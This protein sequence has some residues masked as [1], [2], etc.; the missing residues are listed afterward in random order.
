MSSKKD[1]V[2]IKIIGE[3]TSKMEKLNLDS[4][5][6]DIRRRLEKNNTINDTY[7]F[8]TRHKNEFEEIE[9]DYED[10][11]LLNEIIEKLDN[12]EN[13][14]LYLMKN[15]RLYWKF[16]IKECDIEYGRTVSFDGIKIS[17]KRLFIVQDCGFNLFSAEKY[18][19]GRF[20]C[21]S[22][23]D[24]LKERNLFFSTN[25]NIQGFMELGTSLEDD[26]FQNE[27]ID[28]SII[29]QYIELGKASLKFYKEN[30]KLTQGFKNEVISAIEST[31]PKEFKKIIE[32]YG[33]FIP[34]EV[35]L[36]KRVYFENFK[37][38]SKILADNSK[39]G[40]VG[41]NSKFHNI[42]PDDKSFDENAWIKSLKDYQNWECIEFKNPISIF[43]LLPD[44]LYEKTYKLMGKK[45][46]YKCVE[47][48]D[49]YIYKPGM[50]G[51]YTLKN[52]SQ[53]I[54]D[55]VLNKDAD[56]DIYATV[57]DADKDSKDIIFNC[58]ILHLSNIKPSIIIHGIQK[59][60]QE[61][62]YKLKVG[63]MVIG[64]DM[65]F[66]HI[67]SDINVQSKKVVYDSQNQ[68][69]F[70]S[71]PVGDDFDL[72][73]KNHNPFFGIPILSSYDSSNKSL[74]IGHYFCKDKYGN[75]KINAYS[76]CVKKNC[77]ASLPKFIFHSFIITLNKADS[78]AYASIP[79][80]FDKYEKP[81][82]D[83]TL[84][85]NSLDLKPLFVSLYSPKDFD[86]NPI[87]LNQNNKQ[88]NIEHVNCNCNKTCSVCK[89]NSKQLS[90]DNNYFCVLFDLYSRYFIFVNYHYLFYN[91]KLLI[92]FLYQL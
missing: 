51:T 87:F 27:N 48:Y 35:I 89:N 19:K 29:Y 91:K 83:L 15:S 59:Q 66:S 18:N 12:S 69:M 11:M 22:K 43:Q 49:Y 63:I 36:G 28:D 9:R 84:Q 70:D 17:N 86:Y 67:A 64:Y 72:M 52:M 82:I 41:Y 55:I 38:S 32:R 75:Y 50:C 58:Q 16:F 10:D 57:V 39:G 92:N 23:V 78:N 14:F 68:R 53:N 26:T 62:N 61:H 90:K 6:S 7:L 2:F 60:F 71:M 74:V 73:M 25:I 31:D 30:L 77:Y 80:K 88:I 34:T 4:K 13:K 79:F 8:S 33:R 24:W 81:F 37:M 3:S 47:N 56:C 65:Y 45:V 21:K 76:Y 46:L 85:S 5:L 40:L 44:D 54:L 1:R 42:L 20:E